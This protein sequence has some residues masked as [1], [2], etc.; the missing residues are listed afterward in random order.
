V[1]THFW[2]LAIGQLKPLSDHLQLPHIELDESLPKILHALFSNL[3]IGN[4]KILVAIQGSNFFK[5]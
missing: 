3:I 4:P 5:W 1:T 2:L